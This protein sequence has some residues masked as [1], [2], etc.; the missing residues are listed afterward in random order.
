MP[1]HGTTLMM[2][3]PLHAF[4]SPWDCYRLGRNWGTQREADQ[5]P[6]LLQHPGDAQ[7]ELQPKDNR[8]VTDNTL[9][10]TGPQA[11]VAKLNERKAKATGA[12]Q[13]HSRTP[14]QMKNNHGLVE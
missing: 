8:A 13:G 10:T 1:G 12:E 14:Q 7:Q 2:L 5:L 4:V 9:P 6:G 11:H 3:R